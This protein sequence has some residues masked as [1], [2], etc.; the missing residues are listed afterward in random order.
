M[1]L[2]EAH[3]SKLGAR[4]W[5]LW[6]LPSPTPNF[7]DSSLS[8]SSV[9]HFLR[10]KNVLP[11][12]PTYVYTCTN[13][14][15][16]RHWNRWGLALLVIWGTWARACCGGS[17]YILKYGLIVCRAEYSINLWTL[18]NLIS[19]LRDFTFSKQDFVLRLDKVGNFVKW[20]CFCSPSYL[21]FAE[22]WSEGKV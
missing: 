20:G 3:R 17:P 8:F 11:A 18:E 21:F 15:T 5:F 6:R 2:L 7:S 13:T 22:R 10:V 1:V 19:K 14:H 9:N 12:S 4:L 16:H